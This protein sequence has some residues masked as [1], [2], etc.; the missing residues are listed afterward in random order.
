M[1]YT[2]GYKIQIV[3]NW[4]E[5]SFLKNLPKSLIQ[6]V[7]LKQVLQQTQDVSNDKYLKLYK[8]DSNLVD[9]EQS[10]LENS[11]NFFIIIMIIF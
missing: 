1:G 2:E 9:Y 4:G 5:K 3:R 7:S 11:L 8:I 6:I 10:Y